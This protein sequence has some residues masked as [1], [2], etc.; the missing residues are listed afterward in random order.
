MWRLMGYCFPRHTVDRFEDASFQAV[1]CTG[2]NYQLTITKKNIQVEDFVGGVAH[3]V[4]VGELSLS[5]AP[6]TADR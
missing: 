2:N 1:S 4:S 6:A 3:T 5:C